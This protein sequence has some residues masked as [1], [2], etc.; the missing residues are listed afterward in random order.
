MRYVTFALAFVAAIAVRGALAD[1]VTRPAPAPD[2]AAL[3]ARYRTITEDL[4]GNGHH[5]L[6]SR[7]G[8]TEESEALKA[9]ARDAEFVGLDPQQPL[10]VVLPASYFHPDGRTVE[11]SDRAVAVSR[12]DL[13]KS[14]I[15]L[16]RT[17]TGLLLEAKFVIVI[18][19]TLTVCSSSM[20]ATL[21][22]RPAARAP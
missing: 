14:Y 2:E 17:A 19:P 9:F 13:S 7:A 11:F 21:P 10:R 12:E 6:V 15:T 5:C 1:E 18:N 22:F 20:S 3:R 4:D 16:T 8:A